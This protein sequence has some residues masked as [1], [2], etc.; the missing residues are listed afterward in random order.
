MTRSV[1]DW[2]EELVEAHPR[3]FHAP[4]SAPGAAQGYP[5]CGDGW[6][7]LL[8]LACARIEAALADGDTFG[9]LQIKSK[10]A[11]L[12]FYWDGALSKKAETE[13]EEAIDLAEARSA[14]TCEQ[15]GAPGRLFERGDWLMTACG[16]HGK[17]RPIEVEPGLENIH[18][19][20]GYEG[21][22]S[23]IIACR[24]YDRETDSFLDVDPR[25][26]G[27]EDEP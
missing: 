25:S 22:D 2:R 11:T 5:E 12:R 26:L 18:I 4:A 16:E 15:C 1:R 20:R 6:R 14:C 13:V 10:Y 7:G 3:L 8:E 19:V 21:D 9:A 24:R 27:I 17:G 23:R